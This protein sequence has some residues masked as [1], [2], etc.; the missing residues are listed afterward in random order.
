MHS[1]APNNYGLTAQWVQGINTVLGSGGYGPAI[2]GL[3]PRAHLLSTPS[4]YD[5]ANVEIADGATGHTI[6][7]KLVFVSA[8]VCSR[9][10]VRR[11]CR[12]GLCGAEVRPRGPA[13]GPAV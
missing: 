5:Y 13:P 1:T 6:L 2:L 9:F 3:T 10:R 4:L 12:A 8:C 7:R 11:I